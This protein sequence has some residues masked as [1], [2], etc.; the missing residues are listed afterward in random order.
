[1]FIY[2]LR[3]ENDENQKELGIKNCNNLFTQKPERRCILLRKI[4]PMAPNQCRCNLIQYRFLKFT[5]CRFLAFPMSLLPEL[6]K[7][8]NQTK[9]GTE[10]KPQTLPLRLQIVQ[11]TIKSCSNIQQKVIMYAAY[12][13]PQ[14]ELDS[15]LKTQNN[16]HIQPMMVFT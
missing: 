13:L 11:L 7:L 1:M 16:F 2:E 12:Q 15:L 5:N 9:K 6:K 8:Q 10:S 4:Q 3:K 14:I